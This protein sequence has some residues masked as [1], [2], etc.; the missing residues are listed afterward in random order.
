MYNAIIVTEPTPT[1]LYTLVNAQIASHPFEVVDDAAALVHFYHSLHGQRQDFSVRVWF[2]NVPNG[3]SLHV[4]PPAF[5]AIHPLDQSYRF[6][7]YGDE[8]DVTRT[9]TEWDVT[10]SDDARF[11]LGIKRRPQ[12]EFADHITVVT[13]RTGTH[14]INFH[15]LVGSDNG[16]FLE[17]TR[18]PLDRPPQE[19]QPDCSVV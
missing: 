10:F 13:G 4:L 19:P 9:Q 7:L 3:P 12:R 11:D 8:A 1:G 2:S 16:Y 6:A 18:T 15:N 17:I 5:E 14:W